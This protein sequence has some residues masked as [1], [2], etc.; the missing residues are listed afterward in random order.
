MHKVQTL[1]YPRRVTQIHL[2]KGIFPSSS[3][4]TGSMMTWIPVFFLVVIAV[5][6]SSPRGTVF[7][8]KVLYRCLLNQYTI[9]LS[10]FDF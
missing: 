5:E 10:A 7:K 6:L 2:G 3:P 9:A 8:E 1:D 4:E